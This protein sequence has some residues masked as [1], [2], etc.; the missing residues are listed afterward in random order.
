MG[1][2][3]LIIEDDHGIQSLLAAVLTRSSIEST[4]VG[5]GDGALKEIGR[6]EFGAILLDLLLPRVN[7]FDV[8]RHLKNTNRKMLGRTIVITAAAEST[9]RGC[10][11]LEMVRCVLR[12]PLDIDQLVEEVQACLDGK[13]EGQRIIRWRSR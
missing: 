1:Q 11:E 10:E 13:I 2:R 9:L 5:D 6:E 7:G 4:T 8:L 12:K 3:V